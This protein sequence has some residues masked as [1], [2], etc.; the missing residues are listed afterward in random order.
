MI[1]DC[2]PPNIARN[3]EAYHIVRTYRQF[4]N[5]KRCSQID[6]KQFITATVMRV[7]QSTA[8]KTFDRKFVQLYI[9]LNPLGY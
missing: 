9:Y 7:E 2:Y 6:R 4:N 5:N 1:Y 8:W 3:W